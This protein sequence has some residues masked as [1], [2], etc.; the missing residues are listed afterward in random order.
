LFFPEHTVD[1]LYTVGSIGT[2]LFL[3]L[4]SSLI[5]RFG[6]FACLVFYLCAE[7]TA[8]FGLVW[9]TQ[10]AHIAFFFILHQLL[11]TLLLFSLDIFLEAEIPSEK[12]TGKIR[13]NYLTV[14]NFAVFLSPF[15]VGS[16]LSVSTYK[17]VYLFSGIFI[18]FLLVL[19]VEHFKDR[20]TKSFKEINFLDSLRKFPRR[21]GL[22]LVF[23][24]NFLLQC[25]Y[26]LMVIYSPLYLHTVIGF[27]W[28]TIGILFT[29]MLL[30]FVLFEAPLGRLFDMIHIERDTMFVGF[31]I[32]SGALIAM[33]FTTTPS[34]FL[35]ATLLFVS[36]IGASFVE[37]SSDYS[38]FKRVTDRDAGLISIFRFTSP[39]AY[40]VAPAVFATLSTFLPLHSVF[41]LLSILMLVGIPLAYKLKAV[42]I[43]LR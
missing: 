17:T 14:N 25:F 30:P 11:P 4:S 8:L 27:D 23:S 13:S 15:I 6:N 39:L 32:M 5:R 3:V 12:V 7:I 36:R 1:L 24:I 21:N 34:F 22:E 16:I 19:V 43:P 41:L 9:S 33:F 10:P 2:L 35:W 18:T 28:A 40:I 31:F 38:F 37:V 26:A 20:P 29:I 42:K